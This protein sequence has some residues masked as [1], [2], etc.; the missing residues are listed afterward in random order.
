MENPESHQKPVVYIFHGDDPLALH[1]QIDNLVKQMGDDPAMVELN[2]TRLDGRQASDDDLRSAA[3]AMP[4]LADRRMVI[5]YNPFVKLNTDATRKRFL[6]LLDGLP[7]STALVLV[8]EDIVERGKW[9]RLPPVET[10]WMRK[11]IH[12]AG[13]R[14]FYRLCALP[15]MNEMT[16]WVRKEAARQGGK[17]TPEAA[18]ALAAHIG[19]DTLAAS[20][21]IEKLLTY[22]DYKRPVEG[23]DVE[24]LTAQGGQ[25]D[26]FD[27]VDAMAN[28]DARLALNQLHRLLEVQDPPSLFGM[29]IRQFRL[30]IQVREVIDEGRGSQVATVLHMHPYVAEKMSG[31][32]RRFSQDQLE[33]I[34]HRLLIVDE[35]MKTSQMTPELA[36]DTFIAEMAR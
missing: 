16:E 25:A 7:S 23:A 22:V 1:R 32:A 10:N 29:I 4:F 35:M 6:S 17:F 24:D 18:S 11:W 28:G 34:F 33:T 12:A 15:T 27:M 36:L 20:Q 2:V 26:I 14:A 31:Q 19:N 13:N 30:L 3:N 21:E 8:V 9:L 5:L